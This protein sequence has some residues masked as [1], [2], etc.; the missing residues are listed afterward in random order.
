MEQ[1]EKV[2]VKQEEERGENG[3]GMNQRDR[4]TAETPG[5]HF[6]RIG[7]AYVL[8]MAVVYAVQY[9]TGWTVRSFFPQ[10][11]TDYDAALIISSLS[12]YLLAMPFLVLF[13]RRIPGMAP[14]KHKMRVGKWFAAFFMSYAAMYLSNLIGLM[15]T[16]GIGLVKGDPVGNP[17]GEVVTEISPLTAVVLMVICAPVV[18]EYIFRKLLVDRTV[19]Y[20]EGTAVVLSGLMFGLFHGNL[21]QFVYAVIL[22]MFFAFIYVKTG[23]L[24]YTIAL[25]AAINFMGSIPG[26]LMMKSEA[27]TA[28]TNLSGDMDELMNLFAVYAQEITIY[29]LYMIFIMVLVIVGVICWALSFKKMKCAP[30]ETVILKGQWFKT[31]VLNVGMIL[32]GLF[33]IWQIVSQ[34]LE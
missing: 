25:H 32:Y 5:K 3:E 10:I 27:F 26:I 1:D 17:L 23:K 13:V 30:G 34:M 8:G 2:L 14:S 18:E 9:L 24:I 31:V 29:I 28:F 33:W 11:L 12:M 15:I 19:R 21:N 16:Q 4:R 22:G 7:F 20:G 6:S